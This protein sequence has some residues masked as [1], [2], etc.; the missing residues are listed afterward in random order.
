MFEEQEKW[1]QSG[2]SQCYN[3]G[4]VGRLYNFVHKSMEKPFTQNDFFETVLELGADQGQHFKFVKH[5]FLRYFQSD[6]R[7]VERNIRED[8]RIERL[9]L[10]AQD[11]SIF[12]DN[13][14]DRIIATCLVVHLPHSYS[15]IKEWKRVLKPNGVLTI[16]V[17][18][19]PG[20]LIRLMRNLI[21]WPKARRLGIIN[22]ERLSYEEHITHFP[23]IRSSILSNFEKRHIIHK[24]FP[25]RFLSWNLSFFDIY[26]LRKL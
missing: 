24:R 1:Y 11:L 26:H 23:A 18:P 25:S 6:I 22:P 19:E 2:Y 3:E 14:I 17:S 21:F 7:T 8:S 20:M 12:Q 5:G 4:L 10:D 15:V 9:V 16:Y 13:S